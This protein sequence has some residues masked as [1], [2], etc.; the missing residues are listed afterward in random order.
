MTEAM[1]EIMEKQ[2]SEAP[3]CIRLL[4]RTL[5]DPPPGEEYPCAEGLNGTEKCDRAMTLFMLGL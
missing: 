5:D 3:E 2:N 1:T 4:L